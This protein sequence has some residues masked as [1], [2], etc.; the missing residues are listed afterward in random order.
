MRKDHVFS[1]YNHPLI[2]P[3][4]RPLFSRGVYDRIHD[5]SRSAPKLDFFLYFDEHFS[6]GSS[7]LF[8]PMQL[9]ERPRHLPDAGPRPRLPRPPQ[10]VPKRGQDGQPR[11]QGRKVPH[12]QGKSLEYSN[13]NRIIILNISGAPP[14][15]RRGRGGARAQAGEQVFITEISH[16]RLID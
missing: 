13:N 1:G 9:P 8:F 15:H 2:E 6:W 14:L 10:G 12:H 4:Y 16:I 11:V 3:D 7:C 5:F